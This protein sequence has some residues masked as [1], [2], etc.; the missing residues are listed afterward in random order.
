[1]NSNMKTIYTCPTA[2]GPLKSLPF[3]LILDQRPM[4]LL[5]QQT[6]S[7]RFIT[8]QKRISQKQESQIETRPTTSIHRHFKLVP[9]H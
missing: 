2:G 3:P 9:Y 8:I 6:I 7:Y 4:A 1:M 5:L